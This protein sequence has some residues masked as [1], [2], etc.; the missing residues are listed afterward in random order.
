MYLGISGAGATPVLLI[1]ST[2]SLPEYLHP[3]TIANGMGVNPNKK[4]A[5]QP[6]KPVLISTRVGGLQNN[7]GGSAWKYLEE[8]YVRYTVHKPGY[9]RIIE[10]IHPTK[11]DKT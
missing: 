6:N 8:N 1:S 5:R 3:R 7:H 9:I 2:T 10:A 11:S 4:N